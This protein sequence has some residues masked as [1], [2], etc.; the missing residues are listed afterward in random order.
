MSQFSPHS[1][2]VLS[3]QRDNC[4]MGHGPPQ[5]RL[6]RTWPLDTLR[7]VPAGGAMSN[8]AGGSSEFP[9]LRLRR[10]WNCREL[11][12]N[13]IPLSSARCLV[14]VFFN[15]RPAFDFIRSRDNSF[16]IIFLV[17]CFG[18]QRRFRGSLSDLEA[19]PV[20]SFSRVEAN[21]GKA[22]LLF[23]KMAGRVSGAVCGVKALRSAVRAAV[24][25]GLFCFSGSGMA[26]DG[27]GQDVATCSTEKKQ[28]VV[29]LKLKDKDT[30]IKF[31]CPKDYEVFPAITSGSIQFCRDSLCEHKAPLAPAFSIE[32]SAAATQTDEERSS[33]GSE[34]K[35]ELSTVYT[36]TMKQQDAT[37]STLYFQCRKKTEG[38]QAVGVEPDAS[39]PG[40]LQND[41]IRCA[42]QVAA[43]GSKAA[44]E[45]SEKERESR[46]SSS[47][48]CTVFRALD[49]RLP[50]KELFVSL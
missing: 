19:S 13:W 39:K 42:F 9:P 48:V 28:S 40:K 37:S 15:R 17:V 45:T 43:Y 14:V 24:V 34:E 26:A 29:S 47:V 11:L 20:N 41:L 8:S 2:S 33:E 3:L 27:K 6:S 18:D 5:W 21:K 25:I 38:N 23:S 46:H 35:Q 7:G 1:N 10:V 12:V 30:P 50:S 32:K 36:L 16:L 44:A 49:A 22:I 4:L 31:A